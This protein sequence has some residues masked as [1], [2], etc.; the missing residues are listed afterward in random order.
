MAAEHT[1][2]LRHVRA[3][4]GFHR[5]DKG[6]LLDRPVWA[7]ARKHV[8]NRPSSIDK[9]TGLAL[10]GH[11]AKL[12]KGATVPFGAALIRE[13]GTLFLLADRKGRHGF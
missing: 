3:A 9:L 1:H 5:H 2:A 6:A 4:M 13:L 11:W 12:V 8:P 10:L 7:T